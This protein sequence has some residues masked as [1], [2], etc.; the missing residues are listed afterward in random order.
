MRQSCLWQTD[1]SAERHPKALGAYYTADA[2]AGFL[3]GWGIRSSED[4]VLEPGFGGGV[5]LRAACERIRSLGGD[6]A[7]QVTGVEIDEEAHAHALDDLRQ[8]FHLTRRGLRCRDFFEVEPGS[9]PADV[10]VGN[11]PF[12]RYQSF[13]GDVRRRALRRARSQG[14]ELARLTSSWAP[15]L[16][17]AAS[18]V[19]PGGRLAMVAPFEIAHASYALPVLGFLAKTFG[20]VT[21]LT[22]SEKLF[23]NLNEDT[24]LVLAEGKGEGACRFAW[25]NLS[26]ASD[27]SDLM[28]GSA[29]TPIDGVSVLDHGSLC[30]GDRRLIEYLLPGNIRELYEQ[31]RQ[32]AD[33][34]PLGDL[35]DVG[36]GYVTGANKY[37]HLSRQKAA[38]L[39]IP[40]RLLKPAVRRGRAFLGLRFTAEDWEAGLDSNDTGYLLHIEDD[41]RLPRAVREYLRNGENS[42]VHMAYKCRVRSP[43]YRVPHVRRPDA[44]LTYMSGV[45]PRLVA[46][47]AG[48][49]APNTLHLVQ[50]REAAPVDAESLAVLWHNSLTSL[51][52]EIVGHALGGGLLKMEPREAQRALVPV[53]SVRCAL[54]E[55]DDICRRQSVDE[56]RGRVDREVLQHALGLTERDCR[57]LRQGRETLLTRR[58]RTGGST[59]N[60]S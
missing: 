20:C 7:K 36:I 15:F 54:D 3:V 55:L 49:V 17:H 38:E 5:F 16:V 50:I 43:W 27:L 4:S 9:L 45:S 2:V 21:L 58:L 59:A 48:A 41:R 29:R 47:A 44:F 53:P 14:V 56:V 60:D 1:R 30:R 26:C 32:S 28:D 39:R 10:V 23:P 33:V 11:P 40:E 25:R 8:E 12:I 57:L 42:G 46:N 19:R 18:M 6:A 31:I 51:S 34:V 13:S 52:A 37:F 24:L 35:A 22:F